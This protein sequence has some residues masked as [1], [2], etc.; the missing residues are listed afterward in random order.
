MDPSGS[1]EEDRSLAAAI[2]RY[3]PAF[4]LQHPFVLALIGFGIVVAVAGIVTFSASYSAVADGP[5]LAPPGTGTFVVQAGETTVYER[6]H[7]PTIRPES[8]T[9]RAPGDEVVPFTPSDHPS[10]VRNNGEELYPIGTFSSVAS[11]SYTVTVTSPGGA[12]VV[13]G[14]LQA[15][16]TWFL[17]TLAGIALAGIGLKLLVRAAQPGPVPPPAARR[18]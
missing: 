15:N 10:A 6:S 12:V 8:V 9:V 16:P 5:I 13:G 2:D 1:P 7:Q 18:A 14:G 11:G 3:R 17:V 4:L